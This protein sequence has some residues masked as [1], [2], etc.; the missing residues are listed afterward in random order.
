MTA[1]LAG[2]AILLGTGVLGLAA[3]RWAKLAAGIAASGVVAACLLGFV[4]A[5]SVL[6]GGAASELAFAW[7][8]P[9]GTARLGLDPLTAFFLLPLL[10]L[11]ALCGIYGASYMLAFVPRRSV[12]PPAFFFNVTVAAMMV[13]LLA[14]DAVLFLVA[15]E[16]MTVASYLLVS[17]EH[18]QA[19]ARRAGWVYLVAAHAGVACLVAL[20]LVLGRSAG[21]FGFASFAAHRSAGGLAV[22]V[23]ALAAVGFG[24]KA[25]VVPLH[26]WLPEAHAAAPSHVSAL[27]SGVL[28]KLGLYGLLRVSTF[29][30]PAPWWGPALLLLGLGGG[31]FGI[32]LAAHQRDIKRALAYSSI[33]NVGIILIALGTGFWGVSHGQP[34]VAAL[35]ICGAL[36]H[37][38]NHA[39][40]KGLL[41]LGAGSILHGAGS[42][43]L[44]RLGGLLGRM[45]GTGSVFI[46]GA[47]AIAG[48]PPLNAFASEWLIYLGLFRGGMIRASGSGLL[49]LFVSAGLAAMGVLAV[50]CFVR[51]VGVGMLGQPR[52]EAARHAHESGGW[53]LGP[54]LILA[55]VLVAFGLAAPR[56]LSLLEAP[57]R[58]IG[59]ASLEVSLAAAQLRPVVVMA[60]ALWA[61]LVAGAAALGLMVRRRRAADDTWGCGY[62]APTARMQYTGRSFAELL[63]ERVLPPL[64][65]AR[66]SIER[67]TAVFPGSARLSSDSTDPL[68]RSVYEPF[69]DRWARRFSR[70]RWLQQGFLHVY[71]SYIAVVVVAA[72]AWASARRWWWGGS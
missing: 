27:M 54:M 67:P 43:D 56:L 71:L 24:V 13:V 38:W 60:V 6:R 30:S 66:V 63:A 36:L 9:V 14:R 17:F 37:V 41:F 53:M 40:M 34:Q 15:W 51:L 39:A 21:D 11:G 59:G 8:V 19:E 12:G 33:E 4:P 61:A 26:V 5:L 44:E 20:A 28:I 29:L 35:G 1:L 42:K 55:G 10:V 2:L 49:L 25:G 16:V 72:L 45:P 31:L 70:L 48:L 57:A 32:S 58:Q 64:L 23:F 65:R 46:V 7:A 50:L 69:F 22:L 47:V 18:E 68:T 52:G 62:H 3:A